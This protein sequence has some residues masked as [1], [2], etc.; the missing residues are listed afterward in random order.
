MWYTDLYKYESIMTMRLHTCCFSLTST[1]NGVQ[2]LHR[3]LHAGR[4]PSQE[5]VACIIVP[6]TTNPSASLDCVSGSFSPPYKRIEIWHICFCVLDMRCPCCHGSHK[7]ESQGL[8]LDM[9]AADCHCAG[10]NNCSTCVPGTYAIGG[11][12][13]CR[14]AFL[15]MRTITFRHS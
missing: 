8:K 7:D 2:A 6:V 11:E 9:A 12:R 10:A 15:E 1:W 14:I 13:I 4:E 3:A 5:Q